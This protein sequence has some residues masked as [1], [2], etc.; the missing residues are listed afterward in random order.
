MRRNRSSQCNAG[1]TSGKSRS[2]EHRTASRSSRE[3]ARLP[4][5]PNA[6]DWDALEA[7]EDE[8]DGEP[9]DDPVE[10]AGV[11]DLWEGDELD[12]EPRPEDGDFW[13]ERDGD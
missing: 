13:I 2:H 11:L 8:A 4:G 3:D 7:G 5:V 1:Q 12:D 10:T 6:I 9:A